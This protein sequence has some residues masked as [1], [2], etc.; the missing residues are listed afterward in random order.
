MSFKPLQI[1][2]ILIH[3]SEKILQC[4]HR[5]IPDGCWVSH[6]IRKVI[7]NPCHW[8]IALKEPRCKLET[9]CTSKW[10]P[11][12]L[13]Q[14][15][16]FFILL[17]NISKGFTRAWIIFV[18]CS[19]GICVV[20]EYFCFR[21]PHKRIIMCV[22][23]TS[24]CISCRIWLV[25]QSKCSNCSLVADRSVAQS[26][27]TS[28]GSTGFRVMDASTILR[29]ACALRNFVSY[30]SACSYLLQQNKHFTGIMEFC[31]ANFGSQ[32]WVI[33]VW[34]CHCLDVNAC[35]WL[36]HA[37]PSAVHTDRSLAGLW[38]GVPLW[39]SRWLHRR[40]PSSYL[41]RFPCTGR[42]LFLRVIFWTKQ[43]AG[44]NLRGV[45]HL[46]SYLK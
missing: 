14:I 2:A 35:G 21:F 34:C 24:G 33:V 20:L 32:V 11:W 27:R 13:A 39:L 12:V 4:M 9:L 28:A 10:C 1:R 45:W 43:I 18:V 3:L 22:A 19:D 42:Q 8:D 40:P 31:A 15:P 37:A 25:A 6:T 44:W 38:D 5:A 41:L 30:A 26:L 17:F 23:L 16:E 29:F 36:E 46:N 7:V